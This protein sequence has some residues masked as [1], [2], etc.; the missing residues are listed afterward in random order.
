MAA[1]SSSARAASVGLGRRRGGRRRSTARPTMRRRRVA[2]LLLV[3]PWSALAVH[4]PGA[5]PGARWPAASPGGKTS[6][7]RAL[8]DGRRP[9]WRSTA[10][11]RFWPRGDRAPAEAAANYR[12]PRA[13]RH[14]C[15]R[16]AAPRSFDRVLVDPPCSALGL[17]PKLLVTATAAERRACAD[18]QRKLVASAA[19]S[20]RRRRRAPTSRCT[21]KP[22]ENEEIVAHI[23]RAHRSRLA[24]ALPR[25]GARRRRLRGLTPSVGGRPAVRPERHARR[26]RLLRRT[27]SSRGGVFGATCATVIH[28]ISSTATLNQLFSAH[29]AR[30]FR[31]HASTPERSKA[32]VARKG[33]HASAKASSRCSATAD[34]DA[35]ALSAE[36]ARLREQVGSHPQGL[37]LNTITDATARAPPSSRLRQ[38]VPDRTPASPPSPRFTTAS[39]RSRAASLE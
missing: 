10:Q 39:S 16:V 28:L 8:M 30:G 33:R 37:A 21:N 5:A 11:R 26:Q 22:G 3:I 19:A 12:V 13:R 1:W 2:T 4:D 24:P 32:R 36:D 34:Y 31:N 9:W 15:A 23:L 35:R 18:Y 20:K 38:E 6:T 17:R 7:M 14:V 27:V 25:L 29:G